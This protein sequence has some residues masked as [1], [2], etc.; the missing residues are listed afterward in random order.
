[1][2]VVNG[3]IVSARTE[4]STLGE[5][6]S[7]LQPSRGLTSVESVYGSI[8][9]LRG[10]GNDVWAPSWAS[11]GGQSASLNAWGGRGT[12]PCHGQA[13]NSVGLELGGARRKVHRASVEKHHHVGDFHGFSGMHPRPVPEHREGWGGLK[14][15]F[16][17]GPSPEAGPDTNLDQ[18]MAMFESQITRTVPSNVENARALPLGKS[19]ESSLLRSG[20]DAGYKQLE[21]EAQFARKSTVVGTSVDLKRKRLEINVSDEIG[22]QADCGWS[23]PLKILLRKGLSVS[24][25][26]GLGRIIIPKRSAET[27]FQQIIDTGKEGTMLEM[28]DYNGS[29]RWFFRFK[30]WIN[31]K[32]RMYVLENTGEFI[33]YHGLKE[34]DIFVVYE[35]NSKNTVVR[36][37][38]GVDLDPLLDSLQVMNAKSSSEKTFSIKEEGLVSTADLG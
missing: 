32:S 25:V 38:K 35:D 4:R 7:G 36:G 12:A 34:H 18:L 24:D 10:G 30:S 28:H 16:H 21:S 8:D 11:F 37:H 23:H 15:H 27:R 29:K 14:R 6:W 31:N 13:P 22:L 20:N 5:G 17:F 26:G 19:K 3:K 9:H 1:M 33:K 2:D